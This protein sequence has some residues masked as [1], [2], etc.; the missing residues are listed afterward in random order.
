MKIVFINGRKRAGKDTLVRYMET[1]GRSKGVRTLAISSIDPVRDAMANMGIAVEQ[2]T[3]EMRAAMSEIGDALQRHLQFR[4]RWV[5]LHAQ[6]ADM[7]AA[8]ILF[9]HMRE[10]DIIETTIEMLK[11]L[12]YRDII[13]VFVNSNRGDA[14]ADSNA[15]DAGVWRDGFYDHVIENNGTI[16]E[17]SHRAVDL[18]RM[19]KPSLMGALL[20]S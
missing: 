14:E 8:H 1:A 2:K 13:K 16:Q 10:P 15:S 20:Q 17:L 9:V 19:L 18:M 5:C 3:P 4:S 12:G 11:T 7:D 6:A